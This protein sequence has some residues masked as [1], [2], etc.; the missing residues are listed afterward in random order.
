MEIIESTLPFEMV[1]TFKDIIAG[2]FEYANNYESKYIV[3]RLEDIYGTTRYNFCCVVG[4]FNSYYQYNSNI[5]FRCK[6]KGK[7]IDIWNGR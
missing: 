1:K 3:K 6:Y 4:K 7:S 2:A 5:Y